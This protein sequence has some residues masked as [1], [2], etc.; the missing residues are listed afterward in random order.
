MFDSF[1]AVTPSIRPVSSDLGPENRDVTERLG[2]PIRS[3][4]QEDRGELVF[5]GMRANREDSNQ[6]LDSGVGEMA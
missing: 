4:E 6:E 2:R 5:A 1:P 3:P